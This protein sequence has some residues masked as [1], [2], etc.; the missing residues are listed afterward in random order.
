MLSFLHKYA[1]N[2]HS[3]NGEDLIIAEIWKRITA[4]Q[5]DGYLYN[6]ESQALGY[7]VEVGSNDGRWLSNTAH[8]I[9]LGWSG[10]FVES[11][12]DLYRKC[13]EN[14]Q[15]NPR[16][17]CQYSRVDA[18][19]INAFVDDHCDLLSLDTDGSDYAIFCGMQARPKIVVVEIDSSIEPP[20][21]RVNS[22]G[23]VGYWTMT[24]AALERGYA[25][26]A[27]SGNLILL[28]Q[29]Y[30]H[31]FPEITGHP[32]LDHELYFNRSWLSK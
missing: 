29:E 3:Q 17:R 14:W 32:L 6:G 10:L 22:D 1:G 25:L 2:V 26:L 12:Y 5:R 18:C 30:M 28:Q 31:L 4:D 27:H 19:N 24:V 16:V 7:C 23:G 9:E 13:K 11:D 20:D 15:D 21:E 8:L